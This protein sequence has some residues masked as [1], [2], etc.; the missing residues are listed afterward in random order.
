MFLCWIAG[1]SWAQ[2]EPREQAVEGLLALPD[3]SGDW[4]SR[5]FLSGD[6]RGARDRWA[7]K[8][9]TFDFHWLQVAQGVVDGGVDE[10]WAYATNLDYYFFLDLGRMNVVPGA[11]VSV[12]AQSRFGTTVNGDTGLLLPV[13]AY[14]YFPFT[15]ELD[16]NVPFAITELNW[17]QFLSEKFGFLVGKVTTMIHANEFTGGEGR[18]Q[19]MNF[20]FIYSAVFAQI[21]PY[22]APAVGVFWQATPNLFVTTMLLNTT[23]AST[24]FG[25]GD[26]GDGT[27]WWTEFN[28]RYEAGRLPG[29]GTIGFAYAFD[30]D[31]A[32]IGGIYIRPGR[33]ISVE[34]KPESWG[35]FFSAWQYL[36]VRGEARGALDPRNGRQDLEGIGVFLMMGL[37]DRDTNP[38][39]FTV[40]AGL[41]GRG[42]IP[43]RGDDTYGLGYFYN[44][45]QDPRPF[46]ENSLADSAQGM[47]V[48][49]NLALAGPIALTF[50]FQWTRSAGERVGDALIAGFRLNLRF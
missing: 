13:N 37:A 5:E 16:E 46:A 6:W 39:S 1:S 35:L 9:I 26:I 12:R 47:E 32:R 7:G 29:G 24:T 23:D 45:L 28:F 41:S 49:Y 36:H 20:Q 4:R 14:Q 10:R 43:G 38:T 11:L 50:D 17:T 31:F 18:T 44:D 40:A 48:Y 15:A 19:F 27:T 30:G 3:Y 25:L 33:E 42:M 21:T 2:S 34:E 8:G 22:S